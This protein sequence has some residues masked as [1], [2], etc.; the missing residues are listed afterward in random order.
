[1]KAIHMFLISLIVAVATVYVACVDAN[2]QHTEFLRVFFVEFPI[3]L[4][5]TW[6][7]VFI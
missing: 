7:S 4:F 6:F 1:M 2:P 5:K 3:A